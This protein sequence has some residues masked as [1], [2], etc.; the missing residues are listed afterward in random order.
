[1][2]VHSLA[3]ALALS[4]ACSRGADGDPE[5]QRTRPGAERAPPFDWAHPAAALELGPEEVA[6]RIGPFEWTAAVEW[7][8]S[9]EG[10][11][12]RRV[13]AVEQHRL[14]QA[15]TGEFEVRAE[16]DPG[17]GR[18]S[19]T[20]REI[21]YAGGMTYA[22][23]RHASFR[24]RPTDHG[25]DARRFRD[26]SFLTARSVARLLGPSLELQPIGDA[27]VLRRAARKLAV[28]LGKGTRP[29]AAPA[30]GGD[31][32]PAPDE[33][34]K[35]RRAFLAGLRPES[36]S[37]ELLL[38]AASGAPLRVRIAASFSVDGDPSAHVTVELLAQVKAIGGEVAAVAPPKGALPDERKAT[39]VAAALEAAGLKKRPEEEKGRAEPAEDAGEE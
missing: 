20:G 18:G 5:R 29:A 25:R 13:R 8:V 10:E 37:G 38:D 4:L 12:A 27:E 36:A 15:A 34:T 17:L 22:R 24:E 14:R 2:R 9:R 26:E 21:V 7:T 19:D 11:D 33:D 28:S 39:G 6:A 32:V 3:V 23:A 31:A 30:T 1:V 16:I 35:R